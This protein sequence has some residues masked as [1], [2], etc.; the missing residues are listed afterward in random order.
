MNVNHPFSTGLAA[1]YRLRKKMHTFVFKI[2]YSKYNSLN[3]EDFIT[4]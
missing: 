4:F 2:K 1:V 3:Y